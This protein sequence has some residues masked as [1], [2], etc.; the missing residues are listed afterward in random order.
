MKQLS[1]TYRA[2]VSALG[3][4]HPSLTRGLALIFFLAGIILCIRML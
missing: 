3:G 4:G 1:Q 2:T